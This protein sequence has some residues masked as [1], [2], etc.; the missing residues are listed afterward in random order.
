MLKLGRA[1]GVAMAADL[2]RQSSD[3]EYSLNGSNNPLQAMATRRKEQSSR[4]A[5]DAHSRLTEHAYLDYSGCR[6]S[7]PVP[8]FPGN[9][10]GAA[11]AHS[12]E[13][14]SVS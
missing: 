9:S 13:I 12:A 6:S 5:Q 7:R 2:Y 14:V 4:H 3:T 1:Q 8:S 11:G 10:A